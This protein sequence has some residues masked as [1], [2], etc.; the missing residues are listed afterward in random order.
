MSDE[1]P[2]ECDFCDDESDY[3]LVVDGTARDM[4]REHA[5]KKKPHVVAWLQATLGTPDN[6]R[7]PTTTG[8]G[9]DD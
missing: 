2:P 8:G 4:C 5:E 3:L 1:E 7:D 6:P 9:V